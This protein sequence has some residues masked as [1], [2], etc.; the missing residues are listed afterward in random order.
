[1]IF[2]RVYK[3]GDCFKVKDSVEAFPE[4]GEIDEASKRGIAVTALEDGQEMGCGGI[5]FINEK[6][7]LIWLKLDKRCSLHPCK[8][9]KKVKEVFNIMIDCAGKIKIYA[10]VRDGFCEGERLAKWIKLKKTDMTEKYKGNTYNIY[11]T[12]I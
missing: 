4:L 12:V 7:G 6:E 9:A 10:Y 1:M 2:L 11:S 8:W 3:K 5:S